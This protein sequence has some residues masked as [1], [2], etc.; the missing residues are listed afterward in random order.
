MASVKMP[1][2]GE[3]ITEGTI[4]KWL[5]KPGDQVKKY[6]SLV[7]VITDKVNAEVPSPMAGVLK[8]ILVK[9]GTTISV[10]TDIALIDEVGAKAGGPPAQPG[11]T[12]QP[13]PLGAA[14][15][16]SPA[17]TAAAPAAAGP[18]SGEGRARL[19]PAVRS[20]IEEHRI[21]D[22][23]LGQIKGSGIGGGLVRRMS[24]TSSPLG[25]S[26]RRPRPTGNARRAFRQ[27]PQREPRLA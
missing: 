6:E 21:S 11:G 20:L 10:G 16:A 12:S 15:E 14:K 2:L 26:R 23:E 24:R 19:S 7:E 8:E 22:E 27:P 5:K 17:A 4:S 25:A 3:S 13:Q 18:G 1:Q 9:E